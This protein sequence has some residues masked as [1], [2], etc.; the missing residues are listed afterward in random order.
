MQLLEDTKSTPAAAFQRIFSSSQISLMPSSSSLDAALI[1]NAA[2][3]YWLACQAQFTYASALKWAGA[4]QHAA[5]SRSYQDKVKFQIE[6]LEQ[7]EGSVVV[8]NSDDGKVMRMKAM[9]SLLPGN[10][11]IAEVAK[12]IGWMDEDTYAINSVSRKK[13]P[14]SIYMKINRWRTKEKKRASQAKAALQAQADWSASAPPTQE[15]RI[16][17]PP[18]PQSFVSAIRSHGSEP[19]VQAPANQQCP[20][21]PFVIPPC[22]TTVIHRPPLLNVNADS[23]F[24]QT[25]SPL[26][27]NSSSASS[28]LAQFGNAN[29][30]SRSAASLTTRKKSRQSPALSQSQRRSEK[31]EE[32]IRKSMHIVGTILLD[33][34]RKGENLLEIFKTPDDVASAIN[35]MYEIEGVSGRQLAEAC[36]ADRA[37]EPPPC[38]GRQSRIPDDEFKD[39]AMLFFS[40]SAIEQANAAPN[41]LARPKLISLLGTIVNDKMRQDGVQ[42]IN[43]IHLY[44]RVQKENSSK[45]G[46]V[47]AD[48]REA[49]RVA[50]LTY[51]N[52]KKNYENWESECVR[53]D[54]ARLPANDREKDQEGYIVFH[55]GQES[56]IAN[57]D[58]MSLALDGS[59]ATAG[60][61]PGATPT[62]DSIQESGQS[63]VKSS[64][65]CTCTFGVA[66]IEALPP[67]LIFP[68]SA[69][70][71]E[72]MKLNSKILPSF[73]QV[74]GQY[75][76]SQKYHHDCTIAMSGKG[77][78]NTTIYENWVCEH[79]MPLWPGACDKPRKRVLSKTDFGP[80]RN[81]TSVLARMKVDGHYYFPGLPNGTGAGQEMDALFAAFK[82]CCY[83]N[84]QRLYHARFEID[85]HSAAITL[86]DVGHIIFG[87]KVKLSNGKEIVMEPA[88]ELYF[89]PQHILAARKKCGY[90]PATRAALQS[91]QI[92]HEL[93]EGEE[94]VDEEADPQGALLEQL[95]QLNHGCVSRLTAK[96]YDLADKGKRFVRRI[97]VAQVAGREATRTLPNTR[98]RQDL[99]EKC[100]AA[101]EFFQVTS[102]GAVMNS[103]DMLLSRERKQMRKKAEAMKQLKKKVKEYEKTV[104]KVKHV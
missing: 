7:D 87:G 32:N 31:D 12:L 42:E 58:E 41:R 72:D 10:P 88:F 75:G 13:Q 96:G 35:Q 67:L 77:G 85:G 60:G 20:P 61:R 27:N 53:L 74:E 17:G 5:E 98:A 66:G 40:L 34:V 99:L 89:S 15:N 97:T 23:E 103:V 70:H 76:F 64:Q 82:I 39:I 47:V 18:A 100:S 30:T 19:S 56:R 63:T 104:V 38:R 90:W 3:T 102:G 78:M 81:G 4:G 29:N 26:S 57:W 55:E 73:K 25:L 68:S 16:A 14:S 11:G 65:K 62:L 50:W 1:Q 6:R 71:D 91:S 86:I 21:A 93:V 37:G 101:G 43:E 9:L 46:I 84:R 36:R 59:D 92:R 69:K 80:G 45:Q 83:H 94:G 28:G 44:E 49:I 33:H 8:N 79:V 22:H 51:S 52:Q 24:S 95:E 48:P 2:K 54:F